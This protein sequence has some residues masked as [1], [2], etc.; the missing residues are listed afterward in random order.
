[1][2]IS[3]LSSVVVVGNVVFKPEYHTVGVNTPVVNFVVAANPEVD[4][5]G[6]RSKDDA[7]YMRC[8]LYGDGVENFKASGVEVGTSL[9][10]IGQL[11]VNKNDSSLVW[12]D[13]CH[14]GPN[15]LHAEA[16][17]KASDTRPVHLRKGDKGG[18][19]TTNI[20]FD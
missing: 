16:L 3:N 5:H 7:V 20:E 1:M 11:R 12:V 6:R 10:V 19:M 2:T 14:V 15:F 18:L 8:S 13:V 9:I 17:I 4:I